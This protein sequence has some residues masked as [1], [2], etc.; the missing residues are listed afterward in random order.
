M[1]AV[2]SGEKATGMG[3]L[4]GIELMDGACQAAALTVQ[5]MVVGRKQ[6]V[7]A[8]LTKGFE[9]GIGGTE[10]GIAAVGC[11]TQRYFEVAYGNIGLADNGLKQGEAG[12]VVIATIS[13]AG[14]IELG[15]MLHQV[16]YKQQRQPLGLLSQE[17]DAAV[18]HQ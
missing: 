4:Q 8:C 6:Q 14:S 18:E 9:I 2:G 10:G 13:G 12:G 17:V 11:S 15:T 3:H 1:P 16:A 5:A 7:E